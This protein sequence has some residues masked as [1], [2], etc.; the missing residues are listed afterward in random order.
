[1][2]PTPEEKLNA[3]MA[4]LTYMNEDSTVNE[5]TVFV[6]AEMINTAL[7]HGYGSLAPG[8]WQIVWGP[9]LYEFELVEK[10]QAN[11]TFVAQSISTPT[12]YVVAT[13]GTVGNDLLEWLDEDFLVSLVS[14]PTSTEET[15][16]PKISRATANALK[17]VLK[18]IPPTNTPN[19]CSPLPGAGLTLADFLAMQTKNGP[20]EISFTGHSLGGAIAPGLA[21]WF[22]QAQGD[23]QILKNDIF[24]PMPTWDADSCATISCISFAGATPGDTV[25]HDYFEKLMASNYQRIYNTYDIVPYAFSSLHTLRDLYGDTSPMSDVEILFLEAI[26]CDVAA[27]ERKADT[28]YATLPND[29]PFTGP[30]QMFD[31]K[32][33][34]L[35]QAS[36]QHRQAYV[37]QF[38]VGEN[39]FDC[40]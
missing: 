12:H 18:T 15:S 11:L 9:A 36:Y 13:R 24:S 40:S 5:Q 3:S 39:D 38:G 31:P 14:W 2:V 27:A 8:S 1:M 29:N 20:V 32:W 28:K 34:F 6:T 10:K 19:E 4:F 25:L 7:A 37:V 21:L 23:A 22:R 17:I 26:K 16:S 33:S 35:C 30:L